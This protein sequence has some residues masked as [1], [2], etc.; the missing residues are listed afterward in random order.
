MGAGDRARDNLG[1]VWDFDR[2]GAAGPVD[3]V[4]SITEIRKRFGSGS[5]SHGARSREAHETLAIAM[6]RIG[7]ASCSGEGG[8]DPA[9]AKLRPNGDN[10]N[11][12]VKQIA[13]AR[14]GVTAEDPNH[15]PE[16]EHK[17]APGA[18]AGEGGQ[19]GE[20][21]SQ[22]RVGRGRSGFR[23]TAVC[24]PLCGGLREAEQLGAPAS[25]L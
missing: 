22:G 15:C 23:T 16:S 10:A 9:R 5:R 11:S 4:E 19:S 14:F 21:G 3:Q 12:T 24:M 13:P 6:N 25:F 20:G 17:N 8:E 1:A 18:N 2:V 7:G